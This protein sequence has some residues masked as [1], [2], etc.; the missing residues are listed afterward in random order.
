MAY[1]LSEK[2]AQIIRDYRKLYPIFQDHFYALLHS[3][4]ELQ[5]AYDEEFVKPG[6]KRLEAKYGKTAKT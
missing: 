4:C 2:E 1:K 6:I 3:L 5:D